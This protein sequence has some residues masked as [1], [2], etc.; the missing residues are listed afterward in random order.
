M[1]DDQERD[2]TWRIVGCPIVREISTVDLHLS[3]DRV[4]GEIRFTRW[5]LISTVNR[6]EL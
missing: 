2:V 5:V 3:G 6:K 4:R 1:I